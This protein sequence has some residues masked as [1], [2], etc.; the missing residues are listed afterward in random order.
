MTDTR[1]SCIIAPKN[2][3]RIVIKEEYLAICSE[4]P[5][6]KC[7][8]A[9]LS[10]FE[11]W[12]NFKLDAVEEERRRIQ[13]A[14]KQGK[15]LIP[16]QSTWFFLTQADLKTRELYDLFGETQ[17]A[18]SLK[19]LEA[20]GHIQSRNNPTEKWDRTLQYRLNIQSV[21]AAIDFWD[22][23]RTDNT[24]E[25]EMQS[26]PVR[27]GDLATTEAIPQTLLTE[28]LKEFVRPANGSSKTIPDYDSQRARGYENKY[29]EQSPEE[30]EVLRKKTIAEQVQREHERTEWN[31]DWDA[32][33]LAV[34]THI[35]CAV[36]K[37][38]DQYAHML[39]GTAKQKGYAEWNIPKK[40]IWSKDV[41]NFVVWYKQTYPG[42]VM[43]Q[44]AE[45]LYKHILMWVDAGKPGSSPMMPTPG[46]GVPDMRSMYGGVQ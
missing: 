5:Y 31:S 45:G 35:P 15:V 33:K 13:N 21:Q 36:G 17:I 4:S 14:F 28:S 34:K 16:K 8:A 42:M 30:L 3:R 18:R 46:A 37:L 44:N 25:D 19:H 39:R 1:S 40:T 12:T 2:V 26:L 7:A 38:V 41:S 29:I 27:N 11:H 10:V 32:M 6:P 43:V 23:S 9:I 24:Y 22:T 20:K